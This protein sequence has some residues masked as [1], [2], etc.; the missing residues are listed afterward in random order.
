MSGSE[1]QLTFD[2]EDR[3]NDF[4]DEESFLTLIRPPGVEKD[5]RPIIILLNSHRVGIKSSASR[6]AL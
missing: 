6:Y 1:K 3:S 5:P 2:V 4:D